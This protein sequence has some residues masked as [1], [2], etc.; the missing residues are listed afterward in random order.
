MFQIRSRGSKIKGPSSVWP[1][2]IT[3]C[4]LLCNVLRQISGLSFSPSTNVDPGDLIE[5]IRTG[6]SE[7]VSLPSDSSCWTMGSVFQPAIG[8]GHAMDH[9]VSLE[10]PEVSIWKWWDYPRHDGWLHQIPFYSQTTSSWNFHY[11]SIW[12]YE[13]HS[14]LTDQLFTGCFLR[15]RVQH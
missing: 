15:L 14:S 2:A 8:T 9:N 13:H 4:A 12:G 10:E 5:T 3:V 6:W 7:Q 1:S 11:Y